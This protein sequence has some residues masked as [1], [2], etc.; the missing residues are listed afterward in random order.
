MNG[1]KTLSRRTTG[2]WSVRSGCAYSNPFADVEVDADF[3]APSGKVL[4]MPAFFDGDG[5]WRV[6]FNPG[7][8]G[9]WTA[10]LRA[11][12]HDSD[13]S[14]DWS[15]TVAERSTPGFLTATPGRN[16]GFTYEDG[17]PVFLSGDTTYD[18]FG[19]DY[20][21]GDVAGFLK[22]R[23]EQGFTHFRTRLH[24]SPFHPPEGH[25]DWHTKPMW[26][27]GGSSTAPRFDLFNLDWFRSVD[28][29]VATVDDLGLGLEMIMEGWGFEFPFNHRAWFTPEWEAL[30]MRYLIARYDAYSCVWFWTPLNEYEY[31]PNGD[32]NWTPT[33]DRWALRIGRWI[34]A[35]APHGHILSMHNGPRLPPFAERFRADPEAVDA[36][37]FQ[38]WGTRDADLGWLAAGIEESIE[39]AFAGWHGSAV[40]AEW[41]YERN[42]DYALKLPSHE[43]CD[44]NHTR[45]S[46]WRGVMS[47]MGIVTGWENS[48]AP[49][50]DL[51]TDLPGCA[52][53]VV[54]NRLLTGDL[55]FH[56]FAPAAQVVEGDFAPGHRPLA[57]RS[58][59][60]NTLLVWFPAGDAARLS[61][62]GTG[63]WF[64][65]RSAARRPAEAQ[66][67]VWTPPQET[68]ADGHPHDFLLI[69]RA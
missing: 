22:R 34:K 9:R 16:W 18:L 41:G 44:R 62:S 63:E 67:G 33:A 51:E 35:T 19:M 23:K 29:T 3:T 50:M 61:V 68:C 26:P 69:V 64:D 54:I 48:W 36:I 13:L 66:D 32:W 55:P 47:G 39:A 14:G 21:G 17:T 42:P 11:R 45:R 5:T 2:E 58:S 30:W 52:D 24:V 65:T 27:W 6:R 7:E 59:E 53:L 10:R 40:F 15:F 56:D 46:A 20:C 31:Y 12:P 1:P 37:Q 49:W 57:M 43:H 38:E 8:A 25:S 60:G 4:T 28:R